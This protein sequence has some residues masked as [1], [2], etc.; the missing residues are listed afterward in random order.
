MDEAFQSYERAR[1]ETCSLST[2]VIVLILI[3]VLIIVIVLLIIVVLVVVV[4]EWKA[5]QEEP[6]GLARVARGRKEGGS[7]SDSMGGGGDG[8]SET[9]HAVHVILI[10]LIIVVLHSQRHVALILEVGHVV[11]GEV[12]RGGAGH[13]ELGVPVKDQVQVGL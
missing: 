6:I 11:A 1:G 2:H 3:V 12:D 5:L 7:E 13:L 9:H 4:T 10:I 8:M